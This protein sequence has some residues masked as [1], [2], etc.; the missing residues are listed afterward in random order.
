MAL[1]T[2][3]RNLLTTLVPEPKT[4]PS[5]Q[6]RPEQ[7]ATELKRRLARLQHEQQQQRLRAA[8][9]RDTNAQA[10]QEQRRSSYAGF[11]ISLHDQDEEESADESHIEVG[12]AAIESVDDF[13]NI[14]AASEER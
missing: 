9:Q 13:F 1:T 7:T 2:H 8:K 6:T 10:T 12:S 11:A 14:D 4:V 5:W 3:E